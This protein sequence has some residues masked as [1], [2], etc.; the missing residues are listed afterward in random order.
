[1]G[2]GR[3]Y[4]DAEPAVQSAERH[5]T[6]TLPDVQLTL[7]TDRGVFAHGQVDAGTKHLLL[8]V[9]LPPAGATDLADVGC[10]YGAIALTIARRAPT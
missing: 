2:S 6:L 1:M 5:V 7:A 10:G 8:E 9:P 3:H 4:F